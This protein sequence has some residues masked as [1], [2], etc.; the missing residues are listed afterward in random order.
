MS[1]ERSRRPL[2]AANWKMNLGK[3]DAAEC[4]RTLKRGLAAPPPVDVRVVIF[5]SFPLIPVVVRELVDSALLS[6]T[7]AEIRRAGDSIR[8]NRLERIGSWCKTCV[9]CDL[10]GICR[11]KGA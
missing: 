11:P 5:P 7:E 4:C 2:V 6:G 3:A 10:A 1:P 9:T 8:E